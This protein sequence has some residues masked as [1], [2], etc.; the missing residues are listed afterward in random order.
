MRIDGS[1]Y[2]NLVVTLLLSDRR[3]FVNL[4]R[5]KYLSINSALRY[6]YLADTT[7]PTQTLTNALPR[8]A[9]PRRAK[10]NLANF[11]Q[12]RFCSTFSVSLL[13]FV[14]RCWVSDPRLRAA[15]L[16]CVCK[17]Y[18]IHLSRFIYTDCAE[19]ICFYNLVYG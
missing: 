18:I 2:N 4:I 7:N 5:N 10:P 16:L 15:R 17:L 1:N 3:T 12:I 13:C 11:C 8:Q 14:S 19:I 6:D 9:A